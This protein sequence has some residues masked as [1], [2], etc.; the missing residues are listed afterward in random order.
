MENNKEENSLHI[1]ENASKDI[2]YHYKRIERASDQKKEKPKGLKGLF[3]NKALL[4][5]LCDIILIILIYYFVQSPLMDTLNK[6]NHTII[7]IDDYFIT[8]SGYRIKDKVFARVYIEKEGNT[9][10]R[11]SNMVTVTFSAGDDSIVLTQELPLKNSS[12][13]LGSNP[14]NVGSNSGDNGE[15]V[16]VQAT[17]SCED[18]SKELRAVI[19]IGEKSG[20]LAIIP[21]ER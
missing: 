15:G 13:D 19:E 2:V 3:R 5:I 18:V 12:G 9:E 16:K 17:L 1:K 20:T 14:E 10:I 11:G 21:L 7:N 6:K 8:L 4:L